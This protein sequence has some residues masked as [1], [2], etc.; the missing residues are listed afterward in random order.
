MELD[1]TMISS[2]LTISLGLDEL[3]SITSRIKSISGLGTQV[4][5]VLSG[6]TFSNEAA[7]SVNLSGLKVDLSSGLNLFLVLLQVLYVFPLCYQTLILTGFTILRLGSRHSQG[8]V[9]H[10]GLERPSLTAPSTRNSNAAT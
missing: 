6:M 2:I 4:K 5:S 9:V 10:D 1:I 7:T 8:F 3:Q